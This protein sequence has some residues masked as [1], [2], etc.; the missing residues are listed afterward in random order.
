MF[1]SVI[2][3][4][5]GRTPLD[6]DMDARATPSRPRP[7]VPA[8]QDGLAL[9]A[10]TREIVPLT[11]LPRDATGVVAGV[12]VAPP[13]VLAA[14]DPALER[15]ALRLIEIGFVQGERLRVVAFGQPGDDPIGVRIGGRGGS[16]V[17]ALRRQEA[18]CVWVWPDK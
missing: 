15:M 13:G 4:L 7:A 10:D 16:S 3:R 9:E 6:A 17:F 8:A 2:A 14:T 11:R 1:G 12:R 5:Q 18:G